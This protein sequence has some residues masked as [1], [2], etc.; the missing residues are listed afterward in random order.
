M[1]SVNTY[2]VYCK[3][4]I[5]YQGHFQA[6]EFSIAKVRITFDKSMWNDAITPDFGWKGW[7][8]HESNKCLW[9]PLFFL[10]GVN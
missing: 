4:S 3:T 7:G 2:I 5:Q 8:S 10:L 6:D 9:P 1:V